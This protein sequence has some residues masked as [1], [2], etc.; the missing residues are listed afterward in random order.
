MVGERGITLSGGQRSRLS[1]ARALYADGDI[2]L[3]DDIL[4]A[5]DSKVI[6]KVFEEA[7]LP[8]AKEA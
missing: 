2:F 8:L 3:F 4:S 6:K 1:L 7:I 5:L